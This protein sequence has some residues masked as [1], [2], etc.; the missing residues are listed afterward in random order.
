MESTLDVG[1][2]TVRYVLIEG[3]VVDVRLLSET[4]VSGG[5]G[6]GTSDQYG[7]LTVMPIRIGSEVRNR[8]HAVV[9]WDNGRE[10]SFEADANFAMRVGHR[11]AAIH[12]KLSGGTPRAYVYNRDTGLFWLEA[13]AVPKKKAGIVAIP[14]TLGFFAMFA[15]FLFASMMTYSRDTSGQGLLL[16]LMVILPLVGIIVAFANARSQS[17][18]N[19]ETRAIGKAFKALMTKA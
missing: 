5:G 10:G 4:H 12:W 14:L 2:L 1:G 9:K 19:A 6:G 17:R 15:C 3:E 16:L 8:A 13:I 11:L 7:N 18:L